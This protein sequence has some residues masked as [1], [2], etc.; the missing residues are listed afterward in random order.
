MESKSDLPSPWPVVGVF[1]DH[2]QARA[3][4]ESL[5]AAGVR[6]N[7]IS[8]LARVPAEVW[9]LAKE[10]GADRR[11][12]ESTLR[13]P[14]GDLAAWLAGIG[15]TLPGFGTIAGTGTLGLEVARAGSGGGAITGALVG[16]G[17][18]VD[19]AA[20]YEEEVFDGRILVVAHD[21]RHRSVAQDILGR[22]ATE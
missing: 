6:G 12:E 5:E 4:I 22:T 19:E 10:T 11:A 9:E 21:A 2:A 7:A 13:H 15:A 18:P 20:R 1:A 17:V 8:V 14:L 3:A 16:L